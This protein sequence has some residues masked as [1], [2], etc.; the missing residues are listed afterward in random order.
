MED[1][2][3][4]PMYEDDTTYVECGLEGNTEDDEY[5]GMATGVDR[6]IPTPEANDNYVNTSVMFPR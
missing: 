3:L 6:K 1:T 2:P 5:P 4:Y